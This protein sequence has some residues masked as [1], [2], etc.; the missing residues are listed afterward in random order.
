[1]NTDNLAR[2]IA[3]RIAAM[4]PGASET[5]ARI[6]CEVSGADFSEIEDALFGLENKI[7]PLLDEQG[8]ML[9]RSAYRDMVVD[10]PYNIPFEV[11]RIANGRRGPIEI[12]KQ[13]VTRADVDAVVNA[14]NKGLRAGNGV[15]GAVFEEAGFDEMRAA[16]AAIGHCDTGDAV[17]TPGFALKARYVIHAVGPIW[18]GGR[19]GEAELLASCYKR[20]LDVAAENGC[21]SIAFP[22]ISSGIYGYPKEEAWR[23]ALQAC[24]S[25]LREHD[26]LDMKITFCV[27]SE[28][29]KALGERTLDELC[30]E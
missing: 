8:I 14:A 18:S 12:V 17:I 11:R 6:A 15:C 26:E 19:N 2:K 13:G 24:S 22:L 30:E 29:S 21:T 5:I 16:C 10:L 3:E 20:S 7:V 27:L 25:W 9:D 28:S 23:V 4:E 1:M